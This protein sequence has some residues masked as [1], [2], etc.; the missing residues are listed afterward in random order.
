MAAALGAVEEKSETVRPAHNT[1][2][3]QLLSRALPTPQQNLHQHEQSPPA[4]SLQPLH[5]IF[6]VLHD[7]MVQAEQQAAHES[8]GHEA[9]SVAS[10]R[11][12]AEEE[13]EKVRQDTKRLQQRQRDL[14][15]RMEA[16]DSQVHPSQSLQF[17]PTYVQG[18]I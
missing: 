15:A 14:D 9:R 12:A 8:L 18:L 13:A 3:P 11:A 5:G 1:F 4:Q 10:T 16:F 6:S 17:A 2:T 7:T